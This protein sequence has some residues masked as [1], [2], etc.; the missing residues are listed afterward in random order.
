MKHITGILIGLLM[1]VAQPIV[2]SATDPVLRLTQAELLLSDAVEP[3]PD[4][5]PW[6][7]QSLPDDWGVTHTDVSGYAW[8]RLR[9]DLPKLPAQPWAVYVPF[10]GP[11]GA[12]YLNGV[13]LGRTI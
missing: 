5:A 10:I 3:P 4:S 6:Q 2:A 7:S 1:L 8:Y 9:F 12:I 13:N 11:L